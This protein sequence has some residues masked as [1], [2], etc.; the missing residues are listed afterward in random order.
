MANIE[1]IVKQ[2][3]QGDRKAFG[4]F[5]SVCRERLL[6]LCRHY[7]NDAVANDL[8][9]D[10]FI[11]IFRH[12]GELKDSEKA[13]AWASTITR[14]VCLLYLRDQKKQATI[15]LSEIDTNDKSLTVESAPVEYDELLR[16]IDTLPDGY[17]RV[18][19]LSVFEGMSHEQI[20]TM[21][22][23]SPHTSSSQLYRAKLSLRRLLSPL[24]LLLA[25]V[26]IPTV[27]YKWIEN[28]DKHYNQKV[29]PT[30]RQQKKPVK[31]SEH[32]VTSP[33]G[34]PLVAVATM[35][36]YKTASTVPTTD[37]DDAVNISATTACDTTINDMTVNDTIA[38]TE[39]NTIVAH[40]AEST[41]NQPSLKHH[42]NAR[43]DRWR[44]MLAY[45][46]INNSDNLQLP[47][48]DAD[49]NETV[50]D[51]VCHHQLPLTLSLSLG[52]RIN[53]HWQVGT[54][55]QYTHLVTKQQVGNT[56]AAI[57]HRQNVNYLGIPLSLMWYNALSPQL[58]IN[59]T[60]SLTMHLPLRSTFDS[61]YLLRGIATE[62]ITERLY[63]GMQWSI[64]LG[65][66][67]EYQLT[68]HI[69]LFVESTLQHYFGSDIETWNTAHPVIFSLPLGLHLRW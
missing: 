35:R 51:S 61:H 55:V 68:P 59:A 62:P 5:Y 38:T 25:A 47:Y 41:D 6:T 2:M 21:L 52:Y 46:G 14:N 32:H 65:L 8:L 17:R 54:G 15:D 43:T 64:G 60:A 22:G 66:G 20:A 12:I 28:S 7:V 42:Q 69:G 31:S 16:I 18:F 44:L 10:A 50:N 29:Q 19:R 4:L 23:I 36:P 39:P 67:V 37:I 34:H 40:H 27:V 13:E 57:H 58:C 9:H 3:Q 1:D 24:V 53:D 56:Y 48:A 49:N 30:V 33:Q 45:S 26:L 11:L 63:P